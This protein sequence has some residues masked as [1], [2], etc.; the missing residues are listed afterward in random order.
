MIN[1]DKSYAYGSF[2][3]VYD[4][5][6][7]YVSTFFETSVIE[8]GTGAVSFLSPIYYG[9]TLK[10]W[11]QEFYWGQRTISVNEVLILLCGAAAAAG[12]FFLN[13]W[14]IRKRD[15]ESAGK[16]MA[17]FIPARVIHVVL[18]VS[19]A[20]WIGMFIKGMMYSRPTFWVLIAVFFGALFLYVL[21]Q[22][23]Y[24][25][26][27]RKVLM[28]KWQLAVVEVLAMGIACVFC[29]DLFGYDAYMPQLEET[30]NISVSISNYFTEYSYTID[31]ECLDWEEYRL[32]NMQVEDQ[33]ELYRMIEA[34]V[35]DQ[36]DLENDAYHTIR[37]RYTL[38]SGRTVDRQ[39]YIDYAQYTREL[40]SLFD[41]TSFRQTTYPYLSELGENVD[42]VWLG[43][44]GESHELVEKD[45]VTV[46]DFLAVYREEMKELP[47]CVI[48]EEIPLA[49]LN[50]EDSTSGN[51]FYMLIYPSCEKSIA[52]LEKM[53]WKV[54]PLLVPERVKEI[55]VEDY[56]ED[57]AETDV[58][59]EQEAAAEIVETEEY[60][61]TY[62]DPEEIAKILP[63][64]MDGNYTE[65]WNESQDNIY[66]EVT[67]E[68][69]G[70]YSV[71]VHCEV[72]DGELPEI[73]EKK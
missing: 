26:D 58:I 59:Y 60:Y 52:C 8:Y 69:P 65:V 45:G 54:E 42:H 72:K 56:R 24:V 64:L 38:D 1:T 70:G 63:V 66:A 20:L 53:G 50:M 7:E 39:Y 68:S 57:Y 14:L 12:F 71:I 11:L 19:G 29:F 47:G 25:T 35:A 4:I 13:R 41:D 61:T 27:F 23:I 28:Y 32:K 17:F 5:F 9:V 33:D 16:S 18:S 22:F 15:A 6:R 21:I 30:E 10:N 3:S 48:M 73:L 67:V 46:E 40:A 37:V 49:S 31:D 43:Y 2:A 55:T 36:D 62:R 34:F 51:D 44:A